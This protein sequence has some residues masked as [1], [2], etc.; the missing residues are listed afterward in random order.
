MFEVLGSLRLRFEAKYKKVQGSRY[1][2]QG[3]RFRV[4]ELMKAAG[5]RRQALGIKRKAPIKI[6]FVFNALNIRLSV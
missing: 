1:K 3:S 6:N 2:V 5:Y 4:N